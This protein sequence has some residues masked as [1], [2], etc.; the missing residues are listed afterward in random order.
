MNSKIE[1]KTL[2]GT[3]RSLNS[4]QKFIVQGLIKKLLS[5]LP[6]QDKHLD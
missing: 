4:D 6:V 3:P 5:Q 1:Q 2:G